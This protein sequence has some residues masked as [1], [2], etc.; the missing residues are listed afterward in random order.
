MPLVSYPDSSSDTENPIPTPTSK[1]L[2]RKRLLSQDQDLPPPLPPT[3][4]DLYAS[5]VR[6]TLQDD[7][8]LHSGRQRVLPHV[9]GHWPSHVYIECKLY[10][11]HWFSCCTQDLLL[12]ISRVSF[13]YRIERFDGLGITHSEYLQR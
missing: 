9:E 2:K 7:L 12:I 4:H 5:N 6:T 8:A 11:P 10:I 13:S 3:F 1:P